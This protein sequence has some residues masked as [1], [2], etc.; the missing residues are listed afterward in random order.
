[1]RG[2]R[3]KIFRY[4]RFAEFLRN[5]D[6]MSEVKI[7]KLTL[8]NLDEFL[9]IFKQVLEEGFPEYGKDLVNF[10]VNKDFS[11]E[12]FIEKVGAGEWL[13]WLAKIEDKVV[14]FYVV[15]NLYGGVSYGTLMGVLKDYRGQGIGKNF[16]KVWEEEVKDLGGHKL[17]F[18]T[19]KKENLPIFFKCGFNQEG[20][21]EKSWFGLDCWL[22]GK[23]IGEPRPE[24][25][26]K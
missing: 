18:I 3:F 21:E 26:L 9:P 16:F 20:F 6:I 17:M 7:G 24:V 10:F 2:W 5:E 13:G 11:K 8:E 15:D 22:L 1:L 14:G 19:Q 4:V 23:I 12:V 25:F